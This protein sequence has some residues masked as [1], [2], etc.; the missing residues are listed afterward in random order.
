MTSQVLPIRF[1]KWKLEIIDQTLLPREEKIVELKDYLQVR[2]AIKQLKVRGAP[3]IGIAA[4]YGYV[5]GVK[6]SVDKGIDIEGAESKVYRELSESRPTAVNLF[7]ALNRLRKVFKNNIR[8]KINH[9]I[10]VYNLLEEASKI[11]K[12]DKESSRNIA[13]NAYPLV[14]NFKT[15]LTHCN[16][17]ALA[18]GKF[19]TALYV[20]RYLQ[21]RNKKVEVYATETRPLLQGARLTGWELEKYK[22]PYRI[23]IDSAA[24]FVMKK[25][26]IDA[27]MVGADRVAA[28]GDTANKIGTLG[29]AIAANRFDIPFYVICP[30][31]SIDYHI[32]SG[33]NIPIEIRSGSEIAYFNS[34][35]IVPDEEKCRNYAFDVTPRALITAIITDRRVIKKPFNKIQKVNSK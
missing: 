1:K 9:K 3:A 15:F 5:L 21:Q 30:E 26:S 14:K 31:S 22:I 11:E 35:K 7:W 24:A 28:N 17:G 20:I 18:T 32:E 29:I 16:T 10:I 19:G 2:D 8:E 4:A 25:E 27:V 13:E 23:I 12:E 33:K 6:N 34:K